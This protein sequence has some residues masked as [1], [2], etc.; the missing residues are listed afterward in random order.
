MVARGGWHKLQIFPSYHGFKETKE[1][2]HG[3]SINTRQKFGK[4]GWNC[5]IICVLLHVI[6]KGQHL[7]RIFPQSW[8]ENN[9]STASSLLWG[10]FHRRRGRK[11]DTVPRHKQ[12]S[13]T[14]LFYLKRAWKKCWK[15]DYNQF[16][17]ESL[18]NI[19]VCRSRQFG[20]HPHCQHTRRW[21]TSKKKKGSVF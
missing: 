13:W 17:L 1:Y 19:C 7:H 14:G 16:I 9:W 2:H 10:Y 4:R 18:L 8:L 15:R 5:I 21:V 11:G 6:H 20:S 12:N 3:N